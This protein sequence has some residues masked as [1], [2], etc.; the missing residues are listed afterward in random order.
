MLQSIIDGI[1]AALDDAFHLP[2]H[3][4]TVWQEL[5][6]PCFS[7]RAVSPEQRHYRGV[8]YFRQQMFAIHY[9]PQSEEWREEM[10]TIIDQLFLVLEYVTADGDQIR[11][12]NMRTEISDDV[13]I[14]MVN[15]DMFVRLE[16]VPGD[17]METLTMAVL[18]EKPE[19]DAQDEPVIYYGVA[20]SAVNTLTLTN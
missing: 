18:P 14:F 16:A 1:V 20:A 10:N 5:E 7:V 17:P 19:L 6:V 11:G 4:E 9:F 15:Y 2:V 12:T 3:T 8:R 13:L